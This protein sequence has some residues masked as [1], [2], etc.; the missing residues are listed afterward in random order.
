M[1][2]L[3]NVGSAESL[4]LVASEPRRIV[5]EPESTNDE[6]VKKRFRI[7][8]KRL[9][10][11]KY[12]SQDGEF[13]F[14]EAEDYREDVFFHRTVW[15]D[16]GSPQTG[17]HQPPQTSTALAATLVD[18]WV[19]FEIDDEHFANEKQLRATIVRPSNRPQ[20]GKLSGRDATFKIIKHHPKARRKRPSW[21]DD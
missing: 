8:R 20:G 4:A 3:A 18:S 11:V 9:G 5:S 1:Y 12:I 2:G 14:I 13:G 19:E 21:R 10:T 16:A 7:Q 15:E 17:K 6:P